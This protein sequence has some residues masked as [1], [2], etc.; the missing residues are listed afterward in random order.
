MTV[1]NS[2]FIVALLFFVFFTTQ[3]VRAANI[4]DLIDQN[5]IDPQTIQDWLAEQEL[6]PLF[7]ID[8]AG[9]S[10]QAS[11]AVQ[12]IFLFTLIALAPTLLIMI[13]SFTRIIIVLHFLRSA[14]GTGQMPPNQILIGLALFLTFFIMG[15]TFMQVQEEA[16]APYTAGEITQAEAL[17]I[18]IQPFR[19]FML[20]NIDLT[21]LAFFAG[22]AEEPI[23]TYEDVSLRVLIP[24]FI[25]GELV[26]GFLFGFFLFIP[27]IVIDMIVA[28]VL[29]GMGMMMLPPAMI[30]TP[31][32]LLLF[33]LV[34][35]WSLVIEILIDTFY[36]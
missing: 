29:M 24:A 18:G 35:G 28:S 19:E 21:N 26:R 33:I 6:D 13:T 7:T 27:F 17:E 1:K 32:K 3:T 12:L 4:Q 20:R 8:F 36:M 9:E 5:V 11:S 23:T 2:F 31:F 30:S 16:F 25:L 15:S 34:D 10:I 14:L 22:L